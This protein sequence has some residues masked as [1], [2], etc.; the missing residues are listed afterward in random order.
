[1][2]GTYERS[3]DLRV[4]RADAIVLLECP[5]ELCLERVLRR[6]AESPQRLRRKGC[7][8]SAYQIDRD[9]LRY[10]LEYAS[11]T[12]P[13]VREQVERYGR[14]KTVVVV[15]A[16]EAMDAFRSDT[17]AG[18]RRRARGRIR[19]ETTEITNAAQ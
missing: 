11:V 3:L 17:A 12:E 10:V 15:Q 13:I 5:P 4:P 7:S 8:G 1:M 6:E 18:R 9:H 19:R 2:D 16:P 14:G